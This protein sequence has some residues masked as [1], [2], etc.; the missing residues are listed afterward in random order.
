VLIIN[1]FEGAG[2]ETYLTIEGLAGYLQLAEQT[3][4]R[5]VLNR[6]VPYHKNKKVIRF[7]LSEIEKWVDNGGIV[8]ATGDCTVSAESEVTEG[9]LFDDVVPPEAVPEVKTESGGTAGDE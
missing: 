9:L 7:R 5:W 4:R 2:L 3:I 8:A 1:G 6:E